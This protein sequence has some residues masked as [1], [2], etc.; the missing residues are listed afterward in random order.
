MLPS[1]PVI[2]GYHGVADVEA[3]HDPVR[4]FVSPSRIRRQ[5][6]S[7]LR[8]RYRFLTV[9][10][11]VAEQGAGGD[12]DRTAVLTFDDGSSDMLTN[13]L[14]ILEELDVPGTVYVCPGLLG[15]PY[16]W[17]S[18]AAGVRFLTEPELHELAA[19]PLV[20]IGS[21]TV[22]HT[23]LDQASGEF[24]Y[25]EMSRSKAMLEAMLGVEVPSFC[26]PRCHFSPACPDAARRAGHTSA[27]TCGERGTWD[28][29]QLKRESFHRNDGPVTFGLKSRSLYYG[30]RD[31]PAARAIRVAT[32]PIRHI[33]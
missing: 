18:S 14:P 22:E 24:A 4:L 8:R 17:L 23:E 2:L 31:N 32:R 16:P 5:V 21:H 28:P 20:E 15:E 13:L 1:P 26:Y 30:V 3:G 10:D 11:F 27:V 7:L 6:R 9:A 12:L 19:S 25:E 29:F 33:R